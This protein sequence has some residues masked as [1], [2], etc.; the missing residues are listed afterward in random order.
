MGRARLVLPPGAGKTWSSTDEARA[1]LQT[2]AV[3]LSGAQGE[4]LA[5]LR[6]QTNRTGD[7]AGFP[8]RAR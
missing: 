1:T 8:I 3:G 5:V 4:W 7:L 2:R 6:V